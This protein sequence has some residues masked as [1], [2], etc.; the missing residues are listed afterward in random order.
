MYLM[1]TCS[2]WCGVAQNQKARVA[3]HPFSRG[4]LLIF[5]QHER[6]AHSFRATAAI[7]MTAGPGRVHSLSSSSHS[8]LRQ[9]NRS[10]S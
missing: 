1:P 4:Q 6:G 3:P 8:K 10:L 9:P 5:L 7:K 2:N